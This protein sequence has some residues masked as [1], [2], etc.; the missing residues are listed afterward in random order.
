ML[1]VL[2]NLVLKSNH[3]ALG[4]SLPVEEF[5]NLVIL[6]IIQRLS[7]ALQTLPTD[8]PILYHT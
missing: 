1:S 5:S 7:D 6:L 4:K 2:L 8:V 3:K